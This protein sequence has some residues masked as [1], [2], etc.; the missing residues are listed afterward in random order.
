MTDQRLHSAFTEEQR[1][2]LKTL[3]V[4]AI[5]EYFDSKGRTVTQW[6]ILAAKIVAAVTI[7]T[8]GIKG[9]LALLGFSYIPRI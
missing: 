4:E 8:A 5:N 2:E 9:F 7:I 1:S 3:M 6:L